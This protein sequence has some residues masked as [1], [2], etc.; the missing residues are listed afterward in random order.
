M[1][2]VGTRFGD[3]VDGSPFRASVHRGEALRRNLEFLHG[4]GRKLH[5]RAAYGVVL[6]VDTID[7]DVHIA[8]AL[9]VDRK[10]LITVLVGVL[11]LG[12]RDAGRQI[13]TVADVTADQ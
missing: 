10:N 2:L 11:R 1:N 13:C 9:S 4:F 7:G 12:P 8:A 5:D 3:Y 6:V